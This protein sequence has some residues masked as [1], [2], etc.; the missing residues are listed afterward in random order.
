MMRINTP[1]V[2]GFPNEIVVAYLY[3]R[4]AE[5]QDAVCDLI[6]LN[7]EQFGQRINTAHGCGWIR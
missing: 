6:M 1:P 3:K 5:T 2:S 7:V 4:M